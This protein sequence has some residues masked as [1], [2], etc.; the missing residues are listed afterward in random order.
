MVVTIATFA[1]LYTKLS[2]M[3]NYENDEISM[4]EEDMAKDDLKALG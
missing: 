4:I 2:I 3:F 1:Y